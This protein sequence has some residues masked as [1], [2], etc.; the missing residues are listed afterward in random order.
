M[1][2]LLCKSTNNCYFR[3]CF[4]RHYQSCTSKQRSFLVL[5]ACSNA[6]QTEFLLVGSHVKGFTALRW[7]TRFYTRHILILTATLKELNASHQ[8]FLD[9]VQV[10]NLHT[11]LPNPCFT[12]CEKFRFF[13]PVAG[14]NPLQ[15][16]LLYLF[17]LLQMLK[18]THVT[19]PCSVPALH[20]PAELSDLK[21]MAK[22]QWPQRK[23]RSFVHLL[24]SMNLR[25]G[26][27]KNS[28]SK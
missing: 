12:S 13:S 7:Y 27:P 26:T 14:G 6:S 3:K 8:I 28:K 19:P 5:L 22:T 25:S 24:L 1:K 15:I 21:Q 2:A 18:Q 11:L 17:L 20:V 9:L 16:I 4:I 23:V 10:T